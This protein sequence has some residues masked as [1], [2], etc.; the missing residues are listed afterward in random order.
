M[1]PTNTGLIVAGLIFVAV[2]IAFD[3]VS[4]VLQ[5][6]SRD[7]ADIEKTKVLGDVFES[8]GNKLVETMQLMHGGLAGDLT[9]RMAMT[10]DPDGRREEANGRST[11]QYPARDNGG[12]QHR[13]TVPSDFPGATAGQGR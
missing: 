7:E 4:S 6:K 12:Q 1:E 11:V 2:Y 8:M 10:I 5:N 13:A 9:R 3:R